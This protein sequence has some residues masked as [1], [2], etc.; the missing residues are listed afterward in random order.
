[1][2][3]AV[4]LAAAKM[5]LQ[6]PEIARERIFVDDDERRESERNHGIEVDEKKRI[7]QLSLSVKNINSIRE[8]KSLSTES[9]C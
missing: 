8:R 6:R 9:R 2:K 1:M 3:M 7:S 5:I 4:R